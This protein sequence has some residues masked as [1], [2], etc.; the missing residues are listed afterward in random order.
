MLKRLL[1]Q[2]KIPWI[3]GL[4]EE[5]KSKIMHEIMQ[6]VVKGKESPEFISNLIND[7]YEKMYVI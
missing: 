2:Y 4:K 6:N 7:C 1:K 3:G 5:V